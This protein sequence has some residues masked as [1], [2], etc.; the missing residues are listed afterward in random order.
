M[1]HSAI[2]LTPA[3]VNGLRPTEHTDKN[4]PY[5]KQCE[6]LMPT[7]WGLRALAEFQWPDPD[8]RMLSMLNW[9]YP[10]YL[11][12]GDMLLLTTQQGVYRAWLSSPQNP[13]ERTIY[14]AEFPTEEAL[15]DTG[16][17]QWDNDWTP[18]ENWSHDADNDW[19]EHEDGSAA[20]LK[21][22]SGDQNNVLV[23]DELYR[24]EVKTSGVQAGSIVPKLG[25]EASLDG[26][27]GNGT[28]I[29][30]TTA[31]SGHPTFE[32]VPTSDF[33]GNVEYVSCL[34]LEEYT[35]AASVHPY[36]I[37]AFENGSWFI[38]RHDDFIYDM[39]S[40]ENGLPVGIFR[41]SMQVQAV[42]RHQQ[43]LLLGGLGGSVIGSSTKFIAE[44]YERW[45]KTSPDEHTT[46]DDASVDS[47]WVVYSE[48]G[49]GDN[50]IPFVKLMAIFELPDLAKYT[51]LKG[52]IMQAIEEGAMGLVPLH[53]TGAIKC[54]RRLGDDV[55][56]YGESGISRL[57]W[58]ELAYRG[59]TRM[60]YREEMVLSRGLLGKR[61]V[62]GDEREH[63][64]LTAQDELYKIPANGELERLGYSEFMGDF[65]ES[66]TIITH[67]PV[68]GY[69]WIADGTVSYLRTRT[70]LCKSTAIQPSSLVRFPYWPFLCGTGINWRAYI[71]DITLPSASEVSINADDHQYSTGDEVTFFSVGGTTELNGNTYTI[72]KVDADNFTLDGTDGDDFT[73][74]T[75]GGYAKKVC[76]VVVETDRFGDGQRPGE[77]D[78]VDVSC[79]DTD[80]TGWQL[81][82]KYR[83]RKGDSFTTKDAVAVADTGH[84][85]VGTPGV[86]FAILLTA[87]D[88]D[89]VDLER[90]EVPAEKGKM[91]LRDLL[92]AE[93]A[94]E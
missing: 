30:Y 38:A 65:S 16:C 68:E 48:R 8:P 27:A 82:M 85:H 56:V 36:D 41:T 72:T 59:G 67:D 54:M 89:K 37:A 86:E 6:N 17:K 24:V 92:D 11:Q 26:W 83:L 40:N 2:D 51:S 61:S 62:A 18:G 94:A 46:S 80:A 14:K 29:W 87:D 42:V 81:Q 93:R 49:G 78:F 63:V 9:P 1:P 20:S 5:L 73:A 70:G 44:V 79:T 53:H 55:I 64:C 47:S 71:E 22:L 32:I 60:G 39:P 19:F 57:R 21:Q 74:F 52:F 34:R 33:V 4:A 35:P 28:Y 84:T 15:N 91:S 76:D 66:V 12:D 43:R 90:L 75:W 45:R 7:E 58:T 25:R 77:V 3:T 23:E 10:M 88:R 13:V 31:G 69:Y 50:D